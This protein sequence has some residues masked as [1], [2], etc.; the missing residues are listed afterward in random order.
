MRELDA[1]LADASRS[2]V[3]RWSDDVTQRLTDADSPLALQTRGALIEFDRA[4]DGQLRVNYSERLVTLLREVRQLRCGGVW[5]VCGRCVGGVWRCM[6]QPPPG[7]LQRCGG[8]V[9]GRQIHR[10]E[11]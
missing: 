6:W 9:D 8:R 3:Q 2:L 7:C 1:R 4:D 11:C 5:A 10:V